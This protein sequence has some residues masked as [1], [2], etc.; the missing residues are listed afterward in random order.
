MCQ[1][2]G[3]INVKNLRSRLLWKEIVEN[4]KRKSF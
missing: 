3:L 2:M 1:G 4:K